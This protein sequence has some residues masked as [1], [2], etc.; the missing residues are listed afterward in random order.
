MNEWNEWKGV[1]SSASVEFFISCV[2]KQAFISNFYDIFIL[3]PAILYNRDSNK[4]YDVQ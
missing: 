2:E 4:S 1:N 3:I